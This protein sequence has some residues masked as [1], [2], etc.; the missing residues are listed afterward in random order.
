M[1]VTPLTCRFCTFEALVM[2]PVRCAS[3]RIYATTRGAADESAFARLWP[4]ATAVR[5]AVAALPEGGVYAINW[6]DT[7]DVL[8]GA[9]IWLLNWFNLTLPMEVP[10]SVDVV[11]PPDAL[12]DGGRVSSTALDSYLLDTL[13]Y[14]CV[15]DASAETREGALYKLYAHPHQT[16]AYTVLAAQPA[17]QQERVLTRLFT[18][19]KPFSAAVWGGIVACFVLSALLMSYFEYEEGTHQWQLGHFHEGG[20]AAA[21]AQPSVG[22]ILAQGFYTSMT[23]FVTSNNEQFIAI[24]LPGRA[25][26]IAY[27]FTIML[28]VS[29]YVANLAAVLSQPPPSSAV[30]SA[31]ADFAAKNVRACVLN[32]TDVL[33]LIA[34]MGPLV[35]SKLPLVVVDSARP[36]DLL[37]ALMGNA[38]HGPRCGGAVVANLDASLALGPAADP[39]GATCSNSLVGPPLNQGLYAL[40]FNRNFNRDHLLALNGLISY[41][42]LSGAYDA[43]QAGGN[44]F[45]AARTN[46]AASALAGESGSA[47]LTLTQFA[48]VFLIL[49]IGALISLC[50]KA[51]TATRAM[52]AARRSSAAAEAASGEEVAQSRRQER[53]ASGGE[54]RRS[55]SGA[56]R[57]GSA[58]AS[59]SAGLA[60]AAVYKRPQETAWF[61]P[62]PT[63][64]GAACVPT[65]SWWWA[66][67]P[68]ARTVSPRRPRSREQPAG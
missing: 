18:W 57:Y 38:T 58:V 39:A 55:R 5:A 61:P 20:R 37:A 51:V 14:D 23:H 33:S 48:G 22:A 10:V 17:P 13:G 29:S 40:A 53:S 16:F 52:A 47:S 4:N 35:T 42:V 7:T 54:R 46:C 25:Y 62:P 12:W 31:F 65:P 6:A 56:Q 49:V 28:I 63:G 60:G 59:A 67:S 26:L 45:G 9:N 24:T 19:L 68:A 64:G 66:P 34:E 3:A 2:Q 36:S 50:L 44:V 32:N 11:R 1:G 21:G 8:T 27:S 15:A 43:A 30:I 41:A